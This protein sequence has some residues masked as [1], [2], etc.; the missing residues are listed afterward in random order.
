MAT[1]EYRTVVL[2]EEHEAF[3]ARMKARGLSA[4][5]VVRRALDILIADPSLFFDPDMTDSSDSNR[6]EGE[7]V[8]A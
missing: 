6:T 5:F 3:L 1:N 7:A 8:P 4:S 2:R